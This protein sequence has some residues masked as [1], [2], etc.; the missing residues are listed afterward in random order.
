[1]KKSI[2]GRGKQRKMKPKNRQE[3]SPFSLLRQEGSFS[4]LVKKK[5]RELM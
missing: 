3:E 4:L 2:D 5:V 1:M